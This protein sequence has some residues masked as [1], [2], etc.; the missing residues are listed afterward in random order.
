[1][2]L[3]PRVHRRHIHENLPA[4]IDDH[5]I[6]VHDAPSVIGRKWRQPSSVTASSSERRRRKRTAQ[7]CGSD[8]V[9]IEQN[10][11]VDLTP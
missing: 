3:S 6:A 11:L 5:D 9:L 2:T 10:T 4:R 7:Y 8:S 1:M